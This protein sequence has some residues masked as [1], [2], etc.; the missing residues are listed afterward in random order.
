MTMAPMMDTEHPPK[1]DMVLLLMTDMELL[2]KHL[3]QNM[4]HPQILHTAPLPKMDTEHLPMTDTEHPL[5]VDT[6]PLL[7]TD[8]ELLL[9]HLP[10]N[11]VHPQIL[12]MARKFLQSNGISKRAKS[13]PFFRDFTDQLNMVHPQIL[14]M[15][16]K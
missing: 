14:H 12:H 8:T 13:Y 15:E 7:M 4:V 10:Q 6:A 5:K 1:G 9:K 16:R 11:M 3:P 2:L